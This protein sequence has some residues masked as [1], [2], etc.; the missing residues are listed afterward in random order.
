VRAF[1][2][3]AFENGTAHY[4]DGFIGAALWF[5]PD[6]H[7][8][9]DALGSLLLR[10]VAEEMHEEAFAV[11]EQMASYHPKEPH[12]Y[13]PLIGVDPGHQGKGYGSTLLKHALASCDGNHQI[14]YLEAS[15]PQSVPLYERH[16]FKVLGEVQVGSS[17]PIFPMSRIPQ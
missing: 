9:E 15:S 12:W 7:P 17:P 16:G 2:G 1:G 14:A 5:P 3:K 6:V 10:T 13:L 11:F 4:V 8:D